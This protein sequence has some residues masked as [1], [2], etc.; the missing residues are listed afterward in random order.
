MH[1]T[2]PVGARL[3]GGGGGMLASAAIPRRTSATRSL[4]RISSL[5]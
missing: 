1:A 4:N 5:A 3:G 2:G